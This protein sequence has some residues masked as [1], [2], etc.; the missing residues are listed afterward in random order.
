MG[1]AAGPVP[2]ALV[3]LEPSA[4]H[5]GAPV[6]GEGTPSPLGLRVGGTAQSSALPSSGS[7]CPPLNVQE[8]WRSSLLMMVLEEASA[9]PIGLP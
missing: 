3:P 4:W 1:S 8:A 5:P 7:R 2:E 6:G 9:G